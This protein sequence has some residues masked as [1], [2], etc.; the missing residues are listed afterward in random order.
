MNNKKAF[1]S[2]AS[3]ILILS[4]SI[5]YAAPATI[6]I[7]GLPSVKCSPSNKEKPW[8]D[9]SRSPECR[10]LDALS[11]LTDEEKIYFG[12]FKL[13]TQ[14]E[15]TEEEKTAQ[16]ITQSVKKKLGL[17][18]LG[19]ASDGPNGI[20]DMSVLFGTE[21]KDRSLNVTAFPNVI[22]LGATWD[23]ELARD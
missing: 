18:D 16:A 22:N 19:G 20:A 21:T 10:A 3:F 11:V 5:L 15:E 14:G 17:P 4:S 8:L 13:N 23:R 2:L 7:P 6:S 9:T 12:Y 1:F